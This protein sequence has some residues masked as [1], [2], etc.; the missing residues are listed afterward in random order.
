MISRLYHYLSTVKK[1]R[2]HQTV[3]PRFLT[4][5]TTFRCN[6]RCIM[7]DSWKKTGSDDLTLAE[8]ENIFRQLPKFDFVRLSGGEPFLR[9]DL[10]EIAGLVQSRLKPM[11][12]HITSNGLFTDR[13]VEFVEKRDKKIPLYLLISMD[14]L[15]TEHNRIRG[16]TEAFAKTTGTLRALA[17][18][19]KKL[20]FHIDVNQT[21][22]DDEGVEQYQLLHDYLKPLGI[23]NQFVIGYDTSATYTTGTEVNVAPESAGEYSS[24]GSLST[25]ALQKLF[26]IGRKHIQSYPL[27]DRIA[28][29][30]Y[31]TGIEN[32]L[33]H[34]K[35]DPNPRCS[36]LHGHMRIMPDGTIPT[37]QFNSAS[38]GN[39]RQ[40]GFAAI[41]NGEKIAPMRQWVESCP[42]CWAECEI[43]P[44]ALYSADL[45]K[46]IHKLL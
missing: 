31:L 19:R 5:I 1:F 15:E 37:C 9:R 22:I 20:N 39:L 27:A 7:C 14:G 26:S 23:K 33:L 18:L 3:L 8:I 29:K 12:L 43:L 46:R 17:P 2:N 25:P 42:G 21:I 30:Y 11:I 16:L 32:R 24:Y 41:W 35:A 4:Y 45:L 13:I 36:A 34:G 38:V 6:A 44:N 10:P 28:K 40:Q